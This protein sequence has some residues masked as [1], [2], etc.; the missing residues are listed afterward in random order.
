MKKYD[1]V[2]ICNALVDILVKVDEADIKR[3]ELNKGVMHLVDEAR[4]KVIL[5]HFL[6]RDHTQ[7]LGGSAMNAIRTLAQLGAKTAFAGMVGKD[8][9]GKQIQDRMS[10]IGIEAKLLETTEHTGTCAILITPDGERTMNTCLGASRMFDE[11]L[12]PKKEIADAKVFHFSGYQWDTDGQMRAMRT[13]IAHAKANKTLVSF[14][15]ADPFVVKR[16]AEEFRAMIKEG[17]DVVFANEA[18]SKLLYDTTP[19][20]AA[21]AIAATGAVAVIKLGSKG[22]MIASGTEVVRV[23]VEKTTVVDTTAAGDMFAAGFLYGFYRNKSLEAC[24]KM[25]S[26]LAADVISRVGATVS[27]E[28]LDRAARV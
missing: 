10:R 25:A 5:D 11:T 4:Q 14:D 21:K 12:V 26:I 28:A 24:G 2:S 18:E 27:D 3:F 7:E 17:A 1:V 6:D 23:G 9:F 8:A 22:A 20:E 15:V 16:H 13:A 19:E